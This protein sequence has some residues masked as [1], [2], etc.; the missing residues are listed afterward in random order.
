MNTPPI[1]LRREGLHVHGKPFT[2]L[3]AELHN[4]SS[5][6]LRA[7][8]EAFARVRELGANTVLAPVS[9]AQ[10]EPAEGDFD[11]TL[12]DGMIRAAERE[13][14]RL[15]PL[16]FGSWKNGMSSYLPAWVK[17]DTT[18]F[19]RAVVAGTGAIEHL[20]PFADENKRA[21][22][23]AFAAL[24]ARIAASDAASRVIMVQVENEVGLL[25]DSRD[26]STR[27][28]FRWQSPVPAEVIDA[29][30]R[31]SGS[32]IRA[33]WADRGC[34]REGE[35]SSVF[36]DGIEADEVFM[37]WGY[38][39]YVDSVAAAGKTVLNI[40]MFANVWLDSE[41]ELDLP[42]E[43]AEAMLAMAGGMRPGIY[44]SGGPVP[45]MAPVWAS[46]ISSL[47][48]VGPDVYFGS[49]DDLFADYR[50]TF[51]HLFIPEM[52]ASPIGVSHMFRAVAEHRALGVSP[53]GVD[54]I[55]Q[56]TAEDSALRDGYRLLAAVTQFHEA[57]PGSI[58]RGFM[59]DADTPS[60]EFAFE[61]ITVTIGTQDPYG[62]QTPTYPAYGA[63]VQDADESF[64]IVGRGFTA[65]F[66]AQ[67][68]RSVGI[69]SVTELDSGDERAVARE[70]NGDQT[71]SGSHVK[72][73]ALGDPAPSIFPI[74]HSDE[75]TGIMR[76]RT[77]AY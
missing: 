19:P 64:L 41:I 58:M 66:S 75:S 45:G 65:R 5:S 46:L 20:S 14:L 22:C 72:L 33:V 74:P 10:F 40:P 6:S 21:D 62:F 15:I 60:A 1:E 56:G 18:R 7:I 37:A 36:G 13:D 42:A 50:G 48:F 47:D 29:V 76:V 38:A 55:V 61:G 34:P 17:R 73:A 23:A 35:W 51:G 43:V 71:G 57:H 53:F 2:V 52:R 68:N 25:G 32:P 30:D 54:S 16:W 27:A 31:A 39:T 63:V 77:Y 44:P 26:R 4:S 9:W 49:F 11:T 59:L 8:D 70:L 12:I 28:E 3:G 24:T 69:L 67:G